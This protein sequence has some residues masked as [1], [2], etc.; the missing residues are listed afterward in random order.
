MKTPCCPEDWLKVGWAWR[1]AFTQRSQIV[2]KSSLA[3]AVAV[4]TVAA[5]AGRTMVDAPSGAMLA[6]LG[7]EKHSKS[8]SN[9]L[10]T[11]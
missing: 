9:L 3:T 5:A 10:L 4:G 6:Q 1:P 11:V 7:C 8:R 2:K